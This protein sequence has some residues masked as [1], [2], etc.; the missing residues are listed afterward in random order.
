MQTFVSHTVNASHRKFILH[1]I[2]EYWL[3]LHEGFLVFNSKNKTKYA[4]V[5]ALP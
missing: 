3:V 5:T 1:L 2:T 4:T